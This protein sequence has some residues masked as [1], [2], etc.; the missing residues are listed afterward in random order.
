MG[1]PDWTSITFQSH[2]SIVL[3]CKPSSNNAA[4]QVSAVTLNYAV[5]INRK[6]F[7]Q[8]GPKRFV[9][10]GTHTDHRLAVAHLHSLQHVV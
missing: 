7:F 4:L 6:Y 2:C 5:E 3:D 9:T 10:R 1:I 8:T